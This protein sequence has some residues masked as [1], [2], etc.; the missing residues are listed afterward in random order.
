MLTKLA[1]R[2]KLLPSFIKSPRDCV[3]GKCVNRANTCA[4]LRDR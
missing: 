2:M 1:D 4:I 3:E